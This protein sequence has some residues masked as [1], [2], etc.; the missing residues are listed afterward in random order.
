MRA[1][2]DRLY[3]LLPAIHRIRDAEQGE[4]LKALL[5]VITEQVNLVEE[6]IAQLYDNWFI[7]TCQDW[8]VPYI[9]DLIGYRQVHEAGD[10]GDV[11]GEQSRARNKIL[12]PRR[13]VANTIRYRR[14]KGTLALLELMAKDVAGWQA[15]AVEFNKFI[16]RTQALNYLRIE[17]GRTV[18]V[19]KSRII[20]LINGPFDELTHTVDVRLIN[21]SHAQGRFNIPSV[22]LFVW[23]L[24]AYSVTKTPAF[25]VESGGSHC[26]TFSVLGN[27]APLFQKLEPE[28]DPTHITDEFNLPVPIRRFLLKQFEDRLYGENKSFYIWEG[29]RIKGSWNITLEPLKKK[30][31]A[32]DLTDWSY[33]PREG[34]VAVD[35]VLGRIAF[36]AKRAP[37]EGV[38]V[39]YHYGFSADIG[40]G[41]YQRTLS[42]PAGS[43]FYKVSQKGTFTTLGTA[44]QKWREENPIHGVIEIEDSR[45]YSEQMNIEFGEGQ[46]SLQLRA[47][48]GKRPVIR[49]LDWRTN[50]PDAMVVSGPSGS[51][52]TLDGLMITGRGMQLN[53]DLE[54][55]TIRHSTLVPG[56]ELDND[57]KPKHTNEP[58]LEI[59]SPNVCLTIEHSIMGAIQVDP[60]MPTIKE[61]PMGKESASDEETVKA[62]CHGI[63]IGVRLDPIRICISDSILDAVTKDSEAIGAPG[64]LVAHTV[65]SMCRC[66]VF[67]Q[68]HVRAIELGENCI[69]N[70]RV[71]VARRQFG[72]LRFCYVFPGSRTPPRYNCQPDLVETPIREKLTSAIMPKD[73][74]QALSAE[75]MRV[76]PQFNST[77]YGSPVYC[78][79]AANCSQEIQRG[80]EDASEMGVFH[81]LFQPQREANLRVRL[82][83]YVPAAADTGIVWAS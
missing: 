62:R 64:C 26:F 41:E 18:D 33:L 80:A 9:A 46:K 3:E 14:R 19:R 79:L 5:R 35:P 40:G 16:G 45:V 60:A 48:N 25:C 49:L 34:T 69:L 61:E 22:G 55:V 56:W 50:Q 29:V 21:S 81:D 39:S 43:E 58:S 65:I 1:N 53:G 37:K 8:V 23:R 15:R 38:W 47:A 78:Q 71:F 83:E 44:L 76:R 63:G 28:L 73:I 30:I 59:F 66:T 6:D 42:Q 4:P 57:C 31:I 75:R 82:A 2:I 11:S 20:D 32:A 72:C 36:P 10:P 77:R 67:G 27:D 17:R 51:R 74:E 68:I 70:D 52:F 12:I 24:K 13:E 54:K 7:E